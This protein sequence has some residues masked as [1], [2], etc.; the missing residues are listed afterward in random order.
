MLPA[1]T[2][3]RSSSGSIGEAGSAGLI[4]T[5]SLIIVFVVYRKERPSQIVASAT[6]NVKRLLE[7]TSLH[8]IYK[9]AV[10]I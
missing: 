1:P 10:I 3:W 9:T 2:A 4:T 6:K 7:I 8:L 5:V